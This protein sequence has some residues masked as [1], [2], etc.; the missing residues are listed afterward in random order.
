MNISLA[1]ARKGCIALILLAG[2]SGCVDPMRGNLPPVRD[3]GA[4]EAGVVPRSPESQAM[5]VHFARVQAN[6]R[7]RGLMR[8]DDG[9][10][11]PV[12]SAQLTNNFIRI[13]LYDE[14]VETPLGPVARET[15][16]RLRRWEQ[17]V[18]MSVEFG[19]SVPLADRASDADKIAAY[20]TRLA[21]LSG[22][23]IRQNVSNPNFNVLILNEDERL[24]IGPRIAELVPGLN[25]GSVQAITGMAPETFCLVFAFSSGERA[26]YS[27]A[28]VVIRAELPDALRDLCI[29]E[30]L[31]QGLG[32]A[33]D[34]PTA[35]PSI[36]NDNEEF[37]L[38]TRQDGLMLRILY[39]R[40]LRPG[41]REAEARPIV[42]TIAFELLGGE[43]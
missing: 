25:E 40:R 27:S 24:N 16:S 33:N 13:A 8:T 14:F 28:L 34:S 37:A 22:L 35:R 20:A 18:R 10:A 6:L 23:S 29:H 4:G 17:P 15:P 26:T 43:S 1:R 38:L 21:G 19:A 42:E 3:D 30:E 11:I 36:F 32:L 2:L 5:R 7:G 41:M 9:G 31:A 12:T 39:D